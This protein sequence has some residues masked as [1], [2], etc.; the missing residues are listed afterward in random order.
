MEA[1]GELGDRHDVPV[2]EDA[3]Q[4]H[5]ASWHGKRAG[6][7][8]LAAAFSFYPAKNLGAAGDGGLVTTSSADMAAKL[9]VLRNY[10]SRIKYEHVMLP[11]NRR[12][13]TIQ[14]A[15][16]RVK[17]PH[18]DAWNAQRISLADAYRARL[19][20]TDLRMPGR[21][22]GTRHV[23]HLF[24]IELDD[25]DGLR[26]A[27]RE[28]GIETGIHYPLAVHLQPALLHLGYRRGAFPNAER[29]AA[30]SLSLP[31]FPELTL[32]QVT[33]VSNAIRSYRQ[34]R[35]PQAA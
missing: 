7:F 25:R 27:L 20:D 15:V 13:D 6:S 14:A 2:I 3:C 29:L 10:G 35:L 16:L 34:G 33:R 28:Q 22:E 11:F 32:E 8:G 9:R 5:G 31:M 18:L 23:Y 21:E 30:T 17:L 24:V 4:A 12:L 26:N 1:I 19:D